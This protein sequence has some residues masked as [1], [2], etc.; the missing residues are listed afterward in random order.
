VLSL[1]TAFPESRFFLVGDTGEQDLELYAAMARDH[2]KQILGVFV[3]D[4]GHGGLIADGGGSL[5]DPTG[6]MWRSLLDI[7]PGNGVA[8]DATAVVASNRSFSSRMAPPSRTSSNDPPPMPRRS[9][10]QSQDSTLEHRRRTLPVSVDTELLLSNDASLMAILSMRGEQ[11]VRRQGLTD[12]EKKKAELQ[13]RVW[14]ARAIVPDSIPLR[15]FQQP[16]QCAEV[17]EILERLHLGTE[18]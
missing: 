7:G 11:W 16:Q 10:T 9:T 5:E 3:R 1:L 17:V 13:V 8:E 14:K 4:A 6:V 18:G 2:A 12:V 15:V